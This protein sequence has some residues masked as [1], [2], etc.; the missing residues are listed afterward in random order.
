PP[1]APPAPFPPAEPD[2]AGAGPAAQPRG[3]R[4]AR[5]EQEPRE[6]RPEEP[7]PGRA[8]NRAQMFILA[9]IAAVLMA[10]TALA[11][12]FR[13]MHRGETESP[14]TVSRLKDLNIGV[15]TPPPGWS[16]DDD[17]RVK[18]GSP[19]V[20]AY[21]R[22]DPEAYMAFG[23][24][25]P[26]KGRT[27]RPSEMKGE[28]MRAFPR[29][30]F[31]EFRVETG[32]ETKWLGEDINPELSLKFRAQTND[33]LF[34]SGEAYAV[35]HKGF[36]YYWLSWCPEPDFES[37]KSEFAAFRGKFKTLELRKDWKET[38]SNVVD[39]KGD[40]VPYTIS[41]SEEV[42]REF[43]IAEEKDPDLD[44]LLRARL[45]RKGDRHAIPEEAELRVYILDGAGEP[46]EVARKFAEDKE[47]ERIRE[48]NP[49]FSPPTF[50]VLTD[51]ELGDPVTGNVPKSAPVVRLKSKVNEST[52]A[53]RLIVASGL[54]VGDKI[55]VVRCWCEA[56][57]RDW[58]ETKLVQIASS[59]R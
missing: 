15:D 4:P 1:P 14:E 24:S 55:V 8:T 51:R 45:T 2:F 12:I 42:W 49:D 30:Q 47:K 50:E 52:N 46:A 31:S 13:L 10:G 57:R 27:P 11:I 29:L 26:G 56:S 58:F 53:A 17:T 41:D 44:K 33:G 39:Y 40:K 23:A 54:K 36:A 32:L 35:A 25:E 43:P 34:W 38:Q 6:R 22:K 16:R 20:L 19:F 59:L 21:R 5:P 48:L 9:G 28:M 3:P 37:L 7:P 18:V